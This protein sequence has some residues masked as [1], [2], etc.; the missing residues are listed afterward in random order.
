MERELR[1]K[2]LKEI[3]N[4]KP[5]T[6]GIRIPYGPEILNLNAYQIPLEYLI[7]N[8]YNGRIASFVKSFERQNHILNA[9]NDADAITIEKFLWESKIDRNKHTIDDLKKNKQRVFGIVTFDGKIIDGNR[10]AMLLKK[11]NAEREEKKQKTIDLNFAKYF[12][13]VVL[14][15]NVKDDKEISRLETIYQMG[16]DKKLDYNPIEKYLKCA[17]LKEVFSFSVSEIAEMMTEDERVIKEWLEIKTLMDDY[18]RHYGYDEIYTRLD[19]REGQFVNLNSYL[20]KYRSK[21]KDKNVRWPYKDKDVAALKSISFDYIRAQYEGKQFRSIGQTSKSGS[22]F[23]YE[24]IWEEFLRNHESKV[25][26]VSDTEKNVEEIRGDN[27]GGDLSKLLETRDAE[28]IKKVSGHL[29]GN[30]NIGESR[31]QNKREADEPMQLIRKA[32]D[33]LKSINTNV[34]SFYD[35]EIDKLLGEMIYVI[36]KYRPMIQKSKKTK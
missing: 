18:L 28:W 31:L 17:D 23:Q 24:D 19:K 26:P 32:L 4:G 36:N 16:E 22:I 21:T 3:Q 10:R 6:S 27:P 25:D 35:M 29:E 11:I 30:L 14:P 12:I 8:K 20:R 9:E 7:Y 15:D 1:I 2:A 33:S 34:D 5:Y 13:A